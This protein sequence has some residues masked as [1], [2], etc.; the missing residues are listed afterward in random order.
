MLVEDFNWETDVDGET[1]L[2][3][4]TC[5]FAFLLCPLQICWVNTVSNT[6]KIFFISAVDGRGAGPGHLAILVDGGRVTS[7]VK[8]LGDHR[9]RAV[10]VPHDSGIHAVDMTFNGLEVP[11]KFA[12]LC[13]H[14]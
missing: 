12:F 2:G 14:K 11:G 3:N 13:S 4:V 8:A 5:Y 9:F 7:Q 6:P 1:Y 10:F